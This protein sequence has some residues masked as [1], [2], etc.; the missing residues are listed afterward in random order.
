M[1][2]HQAAALRGIGRDPSAAA[3]S[4]QEVGAREEAGR[5]EQTED[6]ARWARHCISVAQY[7]LHHP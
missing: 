7:S 3:A 1:D 4:S 6:F 2:R 5:E